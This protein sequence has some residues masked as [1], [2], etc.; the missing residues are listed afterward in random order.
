MS[1][2]EIFCPLG[3]FLIFRPI[4]AADVSVVVQLEQKA[5]MSILPGEKELSK[6]YARRRPKRP[7]RGGTS[8]N[9]PNYCFTPMV[10]SV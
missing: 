6:A 7:A 3:L 1:Q 4:G 9:S 5:K 2:F 8:P 10:G